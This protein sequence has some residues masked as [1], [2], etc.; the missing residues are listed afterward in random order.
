MDDE[1]DLPEL[2]DPEGEHPESS[3]PGEVPDEIGKG[4]D[5]AG[6]VVKVI[7]EALDGDVGGATAAGF[8]AGDG[9]LGTIASSL[10]EDEEE[11][12]EV[13]EGIGTALEM[14]AKLTEVGEGLG[15]IGEHFNSE[16]AGHGA[17]GAGGH[18]APSAPG[19]TGAA[20]RRGTESDLISEEAIFGRTRTTSNVQYHLAVAESD[21]SFT[22]RSVQFQDG[23]SELPTCYI[24]ASCTPHALAGETDVFD[25]EVTL[26]I[27]RGEDQRVFKGLVRRGNVV[28]GADEQHVDLDVV[29]GLW[30]LTQR[31]DSRVFQNWKVPALVEEL[32][33]E[34]LGSRN[35]TVRTEL[36]QEY[37]K[38][39]YLVQYRESEYD[40]IRRLCDEEG[41]WFYFDHSEGDHEI[42]V[43]CDSNEN[44][45]RISGGDNGRIE[46]TEH[47]TAQSMEE[48]AFDFA[49]SRWI[50]PTD[51]V[52][53]D[54]DWTHPP[55]TVRGENTGRSETSGPALETHDHAS[56]ARFHE[57]G[58]SQ[59]GEHTATR[60]A[61]TLSERLDLARQY[62]SCST[63]VV[64][65]EPGHVV[66]LINANE[67]D[68]RYLVLKVSVTGSAG[69]AAGGF[70]A[71]LELIPIALPYRPP[72]PH[73]PT[74][75]GPE[76]ATVVGP[77]GEEI[78]CDKHGR[79]RVQFH[80]D[81][82][83]QRD[84]SAGTW[85]RVA[86]FWAGP[87]WG[88]MFI[89]RIGTEV[90][91]S[92]LGGDPDRPVITGRLYNGDHPVPY[93]LP[94][95][96]TRSTIMTNSSPN[97]NGF[98]ELRF[99]DKAGSEE[100]YIH[101]EK[102]FNEEVKNCH[103][104]H[105]GVD[106]SNTVDRDQTETV[107]RDQTLTVKNNR[108]KTVVVDEEN[109]IKGNRITRVGPDSGND[110]LWVEGHREERVDGDHD[111]LVVTNGNK[112]TDVETG[113]WDI[114]TKGEFKVL[115]DGS[116]E[117]TIHDYIYATTDGRIQLLSGQGEVRYDAAADGN[118]KIST[119]GKAWIKSNADQKLEAG[120]DTFIEAGGKLTI[121]APTEISLTCGST[122]IKLTPSG[123]A[124]AGGSIKIEATSGN[125]E[126]D[127]AGLVKLKG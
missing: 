106:Q 21:V 60:R 18:G 122:I 85:I 90:I 109:Q 71:A 119:T 5:A 4:V 117:L 75:V 52:V 82:R 1:D 116:N 59:Y 33:R 49:R 84:D 65:V 96:K 67:N 31:Q 79:V 47:Q 94:E 30:L 83:G 111:H 101:A 40:F 3:E 118:L 68:G 92:F 91:V 56:A 110:K 50:G 81:R 103:S 19:S 54:Y 74:A 22:V 86:Q 16:G 32:V 34:F 51:A 35:R 69:A 63:S 39:E 124:I 78:H 12:R 102:D 89:P 62:W 14:G 24:E 8:K 66:E 125:V 2:P 42:L 6:K 23:V 17:P 45:P 70:H 20:A 76:T 126:V 108:T 114:T 64:G 104:T 93:E 44:R 87:G 112:L 53:T 107:K 121:T 55:L 115:Q 88:S 43:L 57:Y 41:I 11:A 37:L 97:K 25:K 36:T 127:A 58:G 48:V 113:K 73:R 7:T 15:E 13:L 46:Y 61:R 27:D 100:V 99:E 38:H 123:I 98:N 26:T 105:V 72:A 120:G 10:N 28:D 77:S 80:W 29:P 95:H 9:I